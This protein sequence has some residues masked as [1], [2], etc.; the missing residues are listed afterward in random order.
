[1]AAAGVKVA[2][3][4]NR[5]VSS[6]CGSADVL[7]ALGVKIGLP[8]EVS[9]ACLSEVGIA[10]LFAPTHHPAM[11]HAVAARKQLGV[12]T[13]FNLIGPLSNPANASHQVIGTPDPHW[14]D[15]FAEVLRDMGSR[16]AMV[17]SAD[18]GLDEIT[19][20]TITQVAEVEEGGGV[21]NYTID[22]AHFDVPYT[23]LDA[24]I[25]GDAEVNASILVDIL[26]NKDGPKLDISCLN[27]AAALYVAEKAPSLE[28]G[29]LIAKEAISS[30][31]A[32]EKFEALRAFT[33]KA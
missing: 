33:N 9:E 2:K 22:P 23:E 32:R 6:K 29:F 31:A 25:G 10:F 14:L 11:K 28:Q 26:E 4:G 7:E 15:I 1:V 5:S 19:T 20:T 24:L 21:K 18:D 3:H 30:G 8:R 13:I 12:R 16:R 27:A 17:V